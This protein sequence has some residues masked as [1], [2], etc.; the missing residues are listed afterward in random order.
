MKTVLTA[1]VILT[2]PA[3]VM[4]YGPSA[5]A[6]TA[7]EAAATTTWKG[8]LTGVTTQNKALIEA[9]I[10]KIA[11]VEKVTLTDAGAAEITGKSFTEAQVAS[12]LPTGVSIKK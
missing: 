3:A 12:S 6:K 5:P 8:T 1:L 4:A 11:G 2:A 7:T 9:A 10:K